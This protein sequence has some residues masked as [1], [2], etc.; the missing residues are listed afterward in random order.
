MKHNFS[1]PYGRVDTKLLVDGLFVPTK[2]I[3]RGKLL[4]EPVHIGG[5][6]VQYQGFDQLGTDDQSVLLAV[7]AYLGI[8]G[9]I[10][11][12]HKPGDGVYA[13]QLALDMNLESRDGFP[14]EEKRKLISQKT[15]YYNI[16]KIAGYRNLNAT[17]DL[18]TILNRLSN[19]QARYT[20]KKWD[21]SVN[22]LRYACNKVNN[23]IYVAINPE[24]TR[25]LLGGQHAKIS[26]YERQ[27]LQT[28][29]A[30]L[31]HFW[32]S[33]YIRF[34]CSLG[35]N[36]VHLNKLCR[37]VWGP[38]HDKASKYTVSRRK[39]H[40]KVALNQIA[41]NTKRLYLDI[42]NRWHIEYDKN[43]AYIKRPAQLPLLDWIE[44]SFQGFSL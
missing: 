32:M 39:T 44:N 26:L 33:G 30:K 43:T 31:L 40:I 27:V 13:R 11:K 22:L 21:Y 25:A 9:L 38:N 34:G 4:T 3:K 17:K 5:A 24:M 16:L 41:Q 36:G 35:K 15:T 20:T 28:E 37:H 8:D 1:V 29:V 6:R 10:I 42:E 2:G 12:P 19:V 14:P 18:R 7:C 23:E